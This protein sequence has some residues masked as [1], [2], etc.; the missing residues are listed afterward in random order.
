MAAAMAAAAVLVGGCGAAE[1]SSSSAPKACTSGRDID[2]VDDGSGQAT[3]AAAL[4]AY[5][6]GIESA[7]EREL[8]TVPDTPERAR[9]HE[10]ERAAVRALRLLQE[11]ATRDPD[12]GQWEL[13]E[14]NGDL[15][16]AASV[17]ESPRGGYQV[18]S[19]AFPVEPERCRADARRGRPGP[20][21]S[22]APR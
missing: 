16:A 19:L 21:T 22:A 15:L 3:P 13:R 12:A 8:T 20:D 17:Y 9:V 7:L 4:R 14:D 11:P 5:A 2:Y 18:V 1:V 10:D 6:D